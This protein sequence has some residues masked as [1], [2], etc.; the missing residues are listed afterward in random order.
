MPS[1]LLKTSAPLQNFIGGHF[2]PANGSGRMPLI[3]PATEEIYGE[4]PVSAAADVDAAYAA[5]SAAFPLWRDTTPADRQLALF[6][7]AD[8][9]EARAEEF[10]DLESQ[11]TGKP[12]AS[13]VADEIMQ[14]VDQLRFFAG[15]ARSLEGRAAGEYLAG[16]TSFVRREPVGVIGQVT[17]W[18]YPLNMAVWKIAPALAAGNTVVLKPAESTP[19]TTL[20]LAEIVARHTPAGT[21]NVVLGDRD[22]GVALVE[23]PTPH[24]PSR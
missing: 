10:A 15:A 6:R 7:I 16:H 2:V 12:R 19:L 1:T 13:L 14:S 9:M 23:H 20:L 3:D 21:L 11:D 18:N 22:T 8:E 5:A 4:S 17:P 24:A